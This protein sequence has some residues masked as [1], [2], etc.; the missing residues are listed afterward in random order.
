MV[1]LAFKNVYLVKKWLLSILSKPHFI[2]HEVIWSQ[3]VLQQ[4]GWLPGLEII[5]SFKLDYYFFPSWITCNVK[6][7]L[8]FGSERSVG[9]IFFSL[10]IPYLYCCSSPH[11][12]PIYSALVLEDFSL[13]FSLILNGRFWSLD[14]LQISWSSF[15]LIMFVSWILIFSQSNLE[16][17]ILSMINVLGPEVFF[18]GALEEFLA[19]I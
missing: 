8:I 2:W 1:I 5:I 19:D 10:A 7:D 11:P 14:G 3:Y 12:T 13:W 16:S 4:N 9:R 18:L 6:D 15:L 17:L